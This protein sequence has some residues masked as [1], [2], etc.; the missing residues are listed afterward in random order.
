MSLTFFAAAA[1]A[2]GVDEKARRQLSIDLSKLAIRYG[3]GLQFGAVSWN[4]EAPQIAVERMGGPSRT[5][6]FEVLSSPS[7]I[8]ADGVMTEEI[9]DPFEWEKMNFPSFLLEV[10][11]SPWIEAILFVRVSGEVGKA[12][13]ALE[14]FPRPMSIYQAL[15]DIVARRAWM[16]VPTTAYL[17]DKKS[18]EPKPPPPVDFPPIQEPLE[19]ERQESIFLSS[20]PAFQGDADGVVLAVC[21]RLNS[22]EWEVGE[23]LSV[24]LTRM[25]LE[26]GYGVQFRKTSWNLGWAHDAIV[27]FDSAPGQSLYFEILESPLSSVSD[28]ILARELRDPFDWSNIQLP[29]YLLE[30][31]RQPAAAEALIVRASGEPKFRAPMVKSALNRLPDPVSIFQT[32][33]EIAALRD[34]RSVPTRLFYMT[35]KSGLPWIES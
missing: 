29:N 14:P 31:W 12:R 2:D 9:Q 33:D 30:V 22:D 32:M 23:E 1:L 4:I 19:E 34:D 24:K 5:L 20:R 16:S 25:A 11:A 18:G 28:G 15:D 8:I 35:K 7:D 13:D 21:L 3:Y 26:R 27:L 17:V 6:L 10:W